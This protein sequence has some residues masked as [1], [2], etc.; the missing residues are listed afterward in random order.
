MSVSPS[1]KI[2]TPCP[3]IC[4]C[5]RESTE[6]ILAQTPQSHVTPRLINLSRCATKFRNSPRSCEIIRDVVG[7]HS[8]KWA[9]A[10]KMLG[11]CF[12]L[13]N[14]SAKMQVSHWKEIWKAALLNSKFPKLAYPCVKS[15]LNVECM[16]FFICTSPYIWSC[17]WTL[18]G[19]FCR[20]FINT[21]NSFILQWH[22]VFILFFIVFYLNCIKTLLI[23]IIFIIM[24]VS[25]III[26]T[27]SLI[28]KT[29]RLFQ[30]RT[31]AC[32]DSSSARGGRSVSL[33]TC[34]AMGRTTAETERMRLTAVRP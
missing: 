20:S 29:P 12:F 17:I 3:L 10:A 2:K 16:L 26:I 7:C 32:P 4:I 24:T 18:A 28:A 21:L 6:S 15:L 13:E 31:S 19:G 8:L 1:T 14:L 11:C 23:S 22:N 34:A 30:R 33:W 9:A 27:I 25:I 5:H